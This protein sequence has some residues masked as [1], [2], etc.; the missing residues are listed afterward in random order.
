MHFKKHVF[1]IGNR[2]FPVLVPVGTPAD[3]SEVFLVML[4]GW[5]DVGLYC[6]LFNHFKF[7]RLGHPF[8]IHIK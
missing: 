8:I 7:V 5:L 3:L 4:G 1:T 6:C 2:R